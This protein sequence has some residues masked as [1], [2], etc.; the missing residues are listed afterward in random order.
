MK[1]RIFFILSLLIE[2]AHLVEPLDLLSGLT[3]CGCNGWEKDMEKCCSGV[4]RV[5]KKFP[6]PTYDMGQTIL[7]SFNTQVGSLKKLTN[8]TSA[9]LSSRSVKLLEA[10]SLLSRVDNSPS[11]LLY[12]LRKVLP[13]KT[14]AYCDIVT[15]LK[16]RIGELDKPINAVLNA[17][18]KSL[19]TILKQ[20]DQRFL[21]R[22]QYRCEKIDF[23]QMVKS[24]RLNANT[25]AFIAE[26]AVNNVDNLTFADEDYEAIAIITFLSNLQ[27]LAIHGTNANMASILHTETTSISPF[28]NSCFVALNPLVIDITKLI[29]SASFDS[30]ASVKEY[31]GNFAKI[32]HSHN[33]TLTELLGP[34]EGVKITNAVVNKNLAKSQSAD[35]ST[36][37]RP[38]RK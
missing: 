17:V 29:S 16:E 1:L 22:K 9:I 13:D 5:V 12:Q 3:D 6:Q 18:E 2:I 27:V 31:L 32:I 35:Q 8:S 7:A 26:T 14:L 11:Y 23:I 37:L 10:L 20:F 24:G 30:A 36:T 33:A 25:I 34:F 4:E 19:M 38:V 21:E 15:T 28:L